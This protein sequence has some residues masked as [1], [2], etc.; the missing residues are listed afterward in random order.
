MPKTLSRVSHSDPRF[1]TPEHME[2]IHHEA[3]QRN[4]IDRWSIPTKEELEEIY[5]EFPFK[6]FKCIRTYDMWKQDPVESDYSPPQPIQEEREEQ[7]LER[8]KA[9]EYVPKGP[10]NPYS[11]LCVIVIMSDKQLHY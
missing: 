3:T 6:L 10:N 8:I 7:L 1:F 5:T 4:T 11:K 9:G 2:M